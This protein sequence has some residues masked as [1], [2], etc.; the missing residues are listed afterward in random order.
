MFPFTEPALAFL[1][2]PTSQ[3]ALAAAI[4]PLA[5]LLSW[6]IWRFTIQPFFFPNEPEELPYWIPYFGHARSFF[7]DFNAALDNGRKYFKDTK[8]PYSVWIAGTRIYI[9]TAPTDVADLD[10]NTTTLSYHDTIRDMY[11][12]IGATQDTINKLFVLDPS[13]PYNANLSRPILAVSMLTEY[14]RQQASPGKKLDELLHDRIIPSMYHALDFDDLHEHPSVLGRTA[15]GVRISLLDLCSQLFVRSTAEAFLG[16]TIWK[17]NPDLLRSFRAWERTNW[18]FMYQ[19]PEFMSKDMMSAKDDIIH[20][21]V[22]YFQVPI[23]ER[24]DSSFFA[25]TVESMLRE[26]E[27]SEQE[28]AKIFLLHFW[29]ILG[30]VY[31]VAFWA[32]AYLVYD[33]KLLEDIR[34]EIVPAMEDHKLNEEHLIENSPRLHSLVNEVL[35]LCVTSGLVRDIVKPTLIQ[36]KVLREGSK[37][38]IPYRQLHLN[39]DVWGQDPCSIKPERFVINTKLIN[40]KSY[41]P[42]G[43]GHTLCPGRF[44]ARRS[45]SF[46]VALLV[47]R[48]NISVDTE[49]KENGEQKKA[50]DSVLSFPKM[51]TTKPSP[52]ASLPHEGDDVIV[53]LRKYTKF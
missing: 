8:V 49:R 37:L 9:V 32:I 14:H 47:G 24:R 42:F 6:R 39:R 12:W 29:A 46:A 11:K 28:M 33:A 34:T 16:R 30:N 51:D 10:R 45:V 7:Q 27:C 13:T 41:R 26:M 4:L 50:G 35:R 52:G 48:F 38:M 31:K 36:G 40:S 1:R 20:T 53:F 44:L 21:F 15:E 17:V 23:A 43:G 19:I 3:N 25:Q 18:K 2:I 5:A 22:K